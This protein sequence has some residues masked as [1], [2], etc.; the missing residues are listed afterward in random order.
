M[1][2]RLN[3]A[4]F[5]R[6]IAFRPRPQVQYPARSALR[7]PSSQWRL[8]SDSAKP[9]AADRSKREDA[10]PIEHV[11]EEAAAMA[12]TMGE[13]GPDLSQGTPIEDVRSQPP[14]IATDML[15]AD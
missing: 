9:P 14:H 8:Y 6:P 4:A 15:T 10:K 11:S 2:P 5:T 1:P 3:I 13:Q 12:K 7:L